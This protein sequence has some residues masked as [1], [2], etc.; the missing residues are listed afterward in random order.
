MLHALDPHSN[1][2]EPTEYKEM[3]RR[4]Q[5]HYYGVGMLIAIDGPKVVVMEPFPGSPAAN[6]DLRRG[7]W[8]S[9]VDGKDT[10]GMDTQQVADLLRGPRGTL[11]KVTVKR[12]GAAE[13]LINAVT[14]D[15]IETS[16]VDVY[17]LKPGVAY[18]GVSSFEYSS[19]E[20]D[21]QTGLVWFTKIL[22][23][24]FND[25]K[26]YCKSP[27]YLLRGELIE[28]SGERFHA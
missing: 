20:R 21:V 13:P 18:L 2:I 23:D 19:I 27:L 1:F 8:I 24:P 14:R 22:T 10:T 11:V 28:P 9:A 3:M 15:A 12:E 17:W 4:Q 25:L 7:D 6:A 5:S 26:L 16:A